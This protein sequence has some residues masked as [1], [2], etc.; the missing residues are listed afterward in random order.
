[1]RQ[2][3]GDE[4]LTRAVALVNDARGS[5]WY[6][7]RNSIDLALA[8]LCMMRRGES[9]AKRSA[10]AGD[11]LVRQVLE[12]TDAEALVWLASRTI[13]Y[14]DEHGFPDRFW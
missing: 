6:E 7:E 8:A 11:D 13:S 14:I 5:S 9:D 2:Q 4:A 1:M 10:Q 3:G 12:R